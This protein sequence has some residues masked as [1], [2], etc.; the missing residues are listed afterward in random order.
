MPLADCVKA[1]SGERTIVDFARSPKLPWSD[2]VVSDKTN[3]QRG[4]RVINAVC[5]QVS[6]MTHAAIER[7]RGQDYLCNIAPSDLTLRGWDYIFAQDRR[8]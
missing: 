1:I 3:L 8:S 6:R 5:G 2:V 4:H 7:K